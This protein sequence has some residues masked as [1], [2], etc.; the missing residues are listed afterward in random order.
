[1]NRRR[2]LQGL[3]V[4][5]VVVAGGT[6]WRAID[7]G[8]FTAGG[9]PAYE[10]WQNWREEATTGPM[11]LVRAAI[12]AS[13]PHNTQ[14]W[15]FRVH[16][17]AVELYAERSRNLGSFDPYLREMHLGLGCAIENMM[18]AARAHGYAPELALAE[19]RLE[20]MAARQGRALVAHL[21]LDRA[22]PS[23][24]SLFEAI[25][26]RHTNRGPYDPDQQ[27][28]S[29]LE[30][31]LAS[32]VGMDEDV[33]VALYTGGDQ[34]DLCRRIIVEATE[35]IIADAP[36]VHDSERWFRHSWDAIQTHRDGPTLDAAG[37][38]PL[39][40][41]IAKLLPRPSAEA[42]H[43]YWLDATRDVHVAT[44]P[45]F[46]LILV[47]DLYD[48][49]RSLQAGRVWQRLHLWATTQGLAMQP[50]N[51]PVERVDRERQ[52]GQPPHAADALA[53]LTGDRDA[54]PTF[55][56]R[57]GHPSR[58]APASPRRSVEQVVI[59]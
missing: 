8:V 7:Q 58:S 16:D 11:A 30:Q 52:L 54:R 35:A 53:G 21:D 50:L 44:A 5:T 40:T 24:T 32:L 36:M 4:G 27:L 12:L 17:N 10:P 46:G 28:P 43:R 33:D 26:H 31:E 23:E 14:P 25:P 20:P 3:A 34:L 1:M 56:F 6:V 15:M 59:E 48:R 49:G 45:A 29:D 22:A 19:G 39:M 42:N 55:V 57:I 51:Q 38:S 37:L 13:N 18:L 41:S 9:G 47:P 2:F